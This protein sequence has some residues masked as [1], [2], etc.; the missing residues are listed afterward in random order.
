MEVFYIV[1]IVLLVVFAI[2]SVWGPGGYKE[3]RRAEREL[4]I[5]REHI[6]EIR[7]NNE[8][9]LREIEALRSDKEALE[10]VAR[11]NGYGRPGEIVQQLPADSS[12]KAEPRKQ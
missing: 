10:R 3:M 6:E 5:Q 7:R 4:V 1:C 9:K 12:T 11:E 8:E 2:L